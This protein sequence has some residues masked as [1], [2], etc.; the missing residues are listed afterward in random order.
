MK[1]VRTLKMASVAVNAA[2]AGNL[3]FPQQLTVVGLA[4]EITVNETDE[5]G[6]CS[7]CPCSSS[8]RGCGGHEELG[9]PGRLLNAPS[10][11]SSFL[12]MSMVGASQPPPVEVDVLM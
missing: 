2:A 11:M 10:F 3:Q 8:N 4:V 5:Q 6:Q 12:T 9:T 1:T 7:S